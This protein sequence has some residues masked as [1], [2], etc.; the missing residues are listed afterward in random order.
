VLGEQRPEV[1]VE[2]VRSGRVTEERVDESVRRLL[3]EKF[4]LG[5]FENPYV[6][7]DRAEETVGAGEFTALGEAAQRRSL[8]VPTNHAL[9][10]L[11]GRP[12]LYVRGISEQAA[13]AYGNVVADPVDA[14]L[15]DLAVLRLRTPHEE[16]PGLF[17]SF[18][19]SGSPAF[20]EDELK[21][22]LRLLDAVPTL[23]CVKLERPAVLP[24]I[25]A[26][27]AAL[28][29]DY[30]GERR[31]TPGRR[32]RTGTGPGTTA[33]RTAALHLGGR[34]VTAGRPR[35]RRRPRVPLRARTEPLTARGLIRLPILVKVPGWEP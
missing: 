9:L 31:G 35:R 18:F 32:L 10:P 11:T 27:A 12:N 2:L 16:R 7:P 34:G 28:V 20:P 29:A 21:E 8:T 14:D 5:L 6:D 3:R 24:E 4:R 13:A 1:I 17:E 22:V 30:G 26:K 15:A 19:H 33:V 25:A 23:M